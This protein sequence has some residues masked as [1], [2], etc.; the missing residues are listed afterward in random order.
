MCSIRLFMQRKQKIQLWITFKSFVK[1]WR[2]YSSGDRNRNNLLALDRMNNYLYKA[3][4]HIVNFSKCNLFPTKNLGVLVRTLSMCMYAPDRLE[5]ESVGF[6]DRGKPNHREKNL[7]VQG[8]LPTTNG[9]H[10]WRRRVD[11]NLDHI[12]GGRVLSPL[13][14]PCFLTLASRK[15]FCFPVEEGGGK[16]IFH[17]VPHPLRMFFTA[18]L[19]SLIL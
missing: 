1:I 2:L 19:I 9:T 16:F 11:F 3:W 12:G 13:L 14:H 8:T 18:C 10:K 7:S 6:E 4:C 15:S 5:F 17:S